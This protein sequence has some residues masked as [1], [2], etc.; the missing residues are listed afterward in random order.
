MNHQDVE[1]Y[2]EV[3]REIRDRVDVIS[4]Y[5]TGKI[6]SP[7]KATTIE[8]VGLQF[9]KTFEQIAFSSLIANRDL[10][11]EAYASFAQHW[12]AAKLIKNLRAI[13]PN[14]YPVPVINVP[15]HNTGAK[16]G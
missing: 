15:P 4:L 11:S 2:A 9:R 8:A 1:R 3:M 14:F 5:L 6:G 7:F 10:Y 13:N 16:S 12:E